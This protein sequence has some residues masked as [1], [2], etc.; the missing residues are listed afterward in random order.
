MPAAKTARHT[1]Q[2]PASYEQALTELE[3]IVQAMETGQLSLDDTLASYKRGNL[4]LQFCRGKL[5]AVEQQVQVLDGEQLK[6]MRLEPDEDDDR[7]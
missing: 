7:V 4:L 5:Q 6:P 2:A 1:D 3:Q